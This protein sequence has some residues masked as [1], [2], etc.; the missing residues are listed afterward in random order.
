M[1]RAHCQLLPLPLGGYGG[2]ALVSYFQAT[3]LC[4]HLA[5]IMVLFLTYTAGPT[6]LVQ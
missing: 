4:C 3:P 6:I 5:I 1:K 2:A